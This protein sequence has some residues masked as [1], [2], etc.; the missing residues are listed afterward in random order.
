M[1]KA[2]ET[3]ART[4]VSLATVVWDA[5]YEMMRR[6]GYN[7]NF[8]SYVAD[9]IRRDKE[10]ADQRLLDLEKLNSVDGVADRATRDAKRRA[11]EEGPPEKE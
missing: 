11:S 4:T 1:T 2:K 9:L 10:N 8:S 6:K 3:S 5:A 7:N